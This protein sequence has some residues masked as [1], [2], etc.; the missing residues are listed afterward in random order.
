MN[1]GRALGLVVLC[2]TAGAASRAQNFT[3]VSGV[4]LDDS[5][6]SVPGAA[7]TVIN[8]DTGFRR[9]TQSHPDGGYIVTGVATTGVAI[10]T[11]PVHEGWPLSTSATVISGTMKRSRSSGV[12]ST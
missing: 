11:E 7:V 12:R 9:V 5:S 4:V 8:E 6:A 3:H 10:A 2:L 1:A